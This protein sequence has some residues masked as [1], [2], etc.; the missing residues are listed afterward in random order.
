MSDRYIILASCVFA[1]V[2]VVQLTHR[3]PDEPVEDPSME[4]WCFKL[5]ARFEEHKSMNYGSDCFSDDS[6]V[7]KIVS[8]SHYDSK[9]CVWTFN[10]PA[11]LV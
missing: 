6:D 1:G 10:M 4:G 5:L 8:T 9:I 11:A 3:D 2:R 7:K